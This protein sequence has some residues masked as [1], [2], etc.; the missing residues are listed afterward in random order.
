MVLLEI[1]SCELP[2]A[3]VAKSADAG[4]KIKAGEVSVHSDP[5]PTVNIMCIMF[6]CLMSY[7]LFICLMSYLLFICLMSYLLFL[8]N[9]TY[10]VSVLIT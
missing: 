7:L 3:T 6:I 10:N 1:Y 8:S 5:F 4:D 9:T 2:F